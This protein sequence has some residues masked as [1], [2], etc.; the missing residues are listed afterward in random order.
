MRTK[1]F[2]R[3]VQELRKFIDFE[4][5]QKEYVNKIMDKAAQR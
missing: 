3:N 4:L 2:I 1:T 5:K